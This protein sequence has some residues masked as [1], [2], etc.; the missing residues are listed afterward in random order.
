M[1]KCVGGEFIFRSSQ[2]EERVRQEYET[3]KQ[4]EMEKIYASVE[5]Q[6]EEEHRQGRHS[7]TMSDKCLMILNNIIV[8]RVFLCHIKSA[9]SSCMVCLLLVV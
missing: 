1:E 6:C 9:C 8:G 2:A 5:K 7:Y 3:R 4:A